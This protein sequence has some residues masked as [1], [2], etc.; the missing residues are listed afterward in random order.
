MFFLF[1]EYSLLNNI[2]INTEINYTKNN[3]KEHDWRMSDEKYE[4][5]DNI[6]ETP[7]F[8]VS[9]VYVLLYWTFFAKFFEF[10][11]IFHKIYKLR[12]WGSNLFSYYTLILMWALS[13]V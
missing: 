13:V 2:I 5:F 3:K 12:F 7:S 6:H 8:I 1:L 11:S 9:I 4:Q 10:R